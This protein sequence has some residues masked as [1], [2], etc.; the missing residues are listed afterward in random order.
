M[1]AIIGMSHLALKT[2]LSAKQRDYINKI[3][4][5][6]NA[7]L[8][9][10]ND[11]LDFS[12]IEAGKLDI[13]CVK[14]DIDDV[15]AEVANLAAVKTWEKGLELLVN[16]SPDVPHSLIGDPLRLKQILLNLAGNASKFTEQGE[17]EIS[18]R[19]DGRAEKEAVLNFAVRDTGIGMTQKQQS[20]LF[21]AFSQADSSTTREFGGTGLGLT[22]SKRLSELMGGGYRCRV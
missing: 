21:Q 12:K 6:A 8:G 15:M 17:V 5:A 1:N 20:N 7:L 11:I 16:L 19:L 2:D 14:F 3:D 18:C 4:S 22:I 13:E 9:L 10:I